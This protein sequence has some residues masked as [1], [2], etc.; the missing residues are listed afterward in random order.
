M[1]YQPGSW[2]LP[3]GIPLQK[4]LTMPYPQPGSPNA[5]TISPYAATNNAT[6][7]CQVLP[8]HQLSSNV[9]N[10]A[11]TTIQVQTAAAAAAAGAHTYQ[12]PTYHPNAVGTFA[13]SN[14]PATLHHSTSAVASS[15]APQPSQHTA[16]SMPPSNL[17]NGH[18]HGLPHLQG[19]QIPNN[20]SQHPSAL[21]PSAAAAAAAA[22]FSPLALRTY[23]ASSAAAAAAALNN[24]LAGVPNQTTLSGCTHVMPQQ[25]PNQVNTTTPQLTC[26]PSSPS[27][28]NHLSN[29][30]HNHSH[31]HHHHHQQTLPAAI[32]LNVDVVAMRHHVNN[33]NAANNLSISLKKVS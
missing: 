20:H 7:T 2:Y 27:P 4:M 6:L 15:A 25:T 23:L 29:H 18:G 24:P 1:Q 10:N 12:H 28:Q 31:H 8:N 5:A 22:M 32:N 17:L 11:A 33:I 19:S 14:T 13:C 26:V 9:N 30:S 21:L 16:A 3:W